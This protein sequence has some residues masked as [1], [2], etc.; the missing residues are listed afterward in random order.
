M[1]DQF[2]D[3][4]DPT[5]EET[6]KKEFFIDHELVVLEVLD[7]AGVEQFTT[8]SEFYLKDADGVILVYSLTSERS[9]RDLESIRKQVLLM[10]RNGTEKD[11][12]P[13]IIVGAKSDL[14]E[15]RD[16]KTSSSAARLQAAWDVPFFVTS[17]KMDIGVKDAFHDLIRQLMKRHEHEASYRRH[18]SN[19][20]SKKR[21]KDKDHSCCMM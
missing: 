21:H 4:Y 1:K 15:E 18:T 16:A 3:I 9:L 14:A 7:T 2:V 10:N 17:A 6:F 19:K 13:M 8:I 12:I 11:H 5:I 20:E